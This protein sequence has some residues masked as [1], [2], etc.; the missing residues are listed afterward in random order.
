MSNN[1]SYNV[2]NVCIL[3]ILVKRDKTNIHAECLID[4]ILFMSPLHCH[5][6]NLLLNHACALN[7][8]FRINVYNNCCQFS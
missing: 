2:N 6:K 4:T 3:V 7:H 1:D 5:T 8:A